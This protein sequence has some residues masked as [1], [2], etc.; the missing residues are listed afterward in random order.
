MRLQLIYDNLLGL[1]TAGVVSQLPSAEELSA[2]LA[3]LSHMARE[4]RP[5]LPLR[6]SQESPFPI[7][8][9]SFNHMDPWKIGASGGV[10]GLSPKDGQELSA[11]LWVLEVALE[12]EQVFPS[13]DE[14]LS[15]AGKA[16]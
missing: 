7:R 14:F 8:L 5:P 12:E 1:A 6:N 4:K 15:M 3:H 16:W 11:C 9:A 10:L 13:F 2:G